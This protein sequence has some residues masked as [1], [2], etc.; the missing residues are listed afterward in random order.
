M[1]L[2]T[3]W[4]IRRRLF[5]IVF[6][7]VG[8]GIGTSLI[9]IAN[10]TISTITE[11]TRISQQSQINS[12]SSALSGQLE[13]VTRVN[14][15]LAAYIQASPRQNIGVLWDT[16]NQFFAQTPGG[17][18]RVGFNRVMDETRN[19]TYLFREPTG[20]NT[21]TP[22]TLM[23]TESYPS[24]GLEVMQNAV[25][26][27]IY[28]VGPT[29]GYFAQNDDRM[30]IAA[31]RFPW[32]GAEGLIWVEVSTQAIQDIFTNLLETGILSSNSNYVLV[33]GTGEYIASYS[34]GALSPL[35]TTRVNEDALVE[36]SQQ[37][38]ALTNPI[39]QL[40]TTPF[41]EGTSVY[42]S[43]SPV[44]YTNWK[45]YS[46]TPTS[47][48]DSTIGQSI[49]SA[50]FITIG[51]LGVL[52]I[53]LSQFVKSNVSQPLDE[54]AL[55]AQEIGSGD[56][57]Y[58]I[59]YRQRGD[60]IGRL[61]YAL[62]EMK[63]NIADSYESLSVWSRTLENRVKERTHEAETAREEAQE[64]AQIAAA[65]AQELMTV[66]D[67][68]LFVLGGVSLS[69]VLERLI[70]RTPHLVRADY[71]SVWL[72]ENDEQTLRLAASSTG[73]QHL[74]RRID[75]RDGLGGHVVRTGHSLRVS[76][77]HEWE[78]RLGWLAPTMHRALAVPFLY[79]GKTI[80][81]LIAGRSE[82]MVAFDQGDEHL[83]SLVAN[84]V[85]PIV[86]NAELYEE[87]DGAFA[88]AESANMV[89]T[90]FLASVTHE[91]RTPL[92]L[93][94]N[95]M[96]F[97]RIGMFGEV[98]EEQES[99]LNQTIRGAEHL[100]YLINDLLDVSKIEA[101]EMQLFIQETDIYPVLED[102]VDS[103]MPLAIEKPDVNFITEI[104][105]NLPLVWMDAR[106]IRQVITNLLSNAV[107]FTQKGEVKMTVEIFDDT[108]LIAVSD[109]GIGIPTE[110]MALIFEAFERSQ[111]AKQ[112]GIEGTGLGLSISR[113]LVEAHGGKMW[114]DTEL[115]AGSTFFFTLP[116]HHTFA[117]TDEV[118]DVVEVTH[119]PDA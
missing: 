117:N 32:N 110:E 50:I 31:R 66:Y 99:R 38:N 107:K 85:S 8:L 5:F 87:L 16:V 71:C 88:R 76:D 78:K 52:G 84:I 22:F 93:I 21:T 47:L 90:H 44:F 11:Q 17:F 81:A 30:M 57:R 26:N 41:S 104:T 29:T 12:I 9:I 86:R 36:F 75:I 115:G 63:N 100:L 65:A 23:F 69:H 62:E 27:E 94:I 39:T 98:N 24:N 60:E 109:T 43:S 25:Q 46:L 83:L 79:Q 10:A 6:A 105:P 95:N 111:R 101:G 58:Q 80:G 77:Y 1:G 7:I 3:N 18:T 73:L 92:N 64:N 116:V 114:L 119:K 106:R 59:R 72:L 49:L 91:L 70:E 45:V 53:T 67:F 40:S 20:T 13:G 34:P 14:D 56:M 82:N 54:L 108:L 113:H 19:R 2:F 103:V 74:N 118:Q 4:G 55:A 61:A 112:L 51:G 102:A 68:S 97:M 48:I 28:W 42:A 89:K 33:S 35:R 15:A 96:D 37:L